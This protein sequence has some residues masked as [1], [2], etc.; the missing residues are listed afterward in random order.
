MITVSIVLVTIGS[1]M[2]KRDRGRLGEG[3]ACEV[4]WVMDRLMVNGWMSSCFAWR[5]E[6]FVL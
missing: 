1:P 3:D 2:S 4:R 5:V 6:P